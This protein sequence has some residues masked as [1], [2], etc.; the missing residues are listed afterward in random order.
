MRQ[1]DARIAMNRLV[2]AYRQSQCVRVAAELRIP[3]LLAGGPKTSAELADETTTNEQSLRRLLRALTAMQVLVEEPSG[4]YAVTQFGEEL[5]ADRLGPAALMFNSNLYWQTWQNL[6][7]S[8]RSGER[9][10][11]FVFGMRDWDYYATHADEGARFD[12]AMAANT[13]PVTRAVVAAYDFSR[14]RVIAD[15]G[16]GDGTFLTEI[17]TR[18]PTARGVLFDRPDVIQR[19]RQ[20]L[21]RP[22]LERIQLLSGSFFDVMPTGADLYLMKSIIHDWDDH[23]AR[24]ILDRCRQVCSV[25]SHLALVERVLPEN[26]DPDALEMYIM[27]LNMLVNNGGRE[28]T[29][30]EYG[31]LLSAAGF[32]L[33]RIVATDAGTSVL[34]SVAV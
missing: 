28:R 31:E 2:N 13:G 27:D 19:T 1:P 4:R 14:Y 7:Y 30:N 21:Q 12:A 15:I 22:E 32:H 26:A 3:E 6:S 24:R 16:G 25:G 18:H 5:R 11:D 20:R 9:A 29:A 34:E 17:L 23:N 33:Q 10:F 8:V